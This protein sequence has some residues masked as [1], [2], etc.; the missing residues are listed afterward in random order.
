MG[1][2]LFVS[3]ACPIRLGLCVITDSINVRL[4]WVIAYT[5]LRK[6]VL[7]GYDM[8]RDVLEIQSQRNSSTDEASSLVVGIV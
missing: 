5:C 6:T 7:L 2:R 4:V 8:C 1:A 3:D